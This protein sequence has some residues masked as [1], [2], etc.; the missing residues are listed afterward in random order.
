MNIFKNKKLLFKVGAILL[1]VLAAYSQIKYSKVYKGIPK[2][3]ELIYVNDFA[4]V[5]SEDTKEYIIKFNEY[6][7]SKKE[8]PRIIVATIDSFSGYTSYDYSIKMFNEYNVNQGLKKN[9]VLIIYSKKNDKFYV[10]TWFTS[11][12]KYMKN[13][14][15]YVQE[16]S[17]SLLKEGNIDGAVLN[18]FKNTSNLICNHYNYDA[19]ATGTIDF[20]Y[21]ATVKMM[22][23]VLYRYRFRVIIVGSIIS[24]SF[25]YLK[26]DSFI[27]RKKKKKNAIIDLEN[28]KRK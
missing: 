5:L 15:S 18:V 4:N 23:N 11:T 21:P 22:S 20:E 26:V 6:L 28:K 3:S 7:S 27:E 17:L 24:A 13:R 8:S 1:I 2:Q 10:R 25:V 14:F 12:S 9:G 19:I 16:S